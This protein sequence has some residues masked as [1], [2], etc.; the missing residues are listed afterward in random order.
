MA[1]FAKITEANEVLTVVVV[2]NSDVQDENNNEVESVG[3]QYLQTH[4]NWPAE[5]WIQCSYNTYRN[6]HSLGGT[7]FRGNY[8]SIGYTWD[9]TNSIF[10]E[11]QPHG[12]WTKNTSNASWEAPITYPSIEENYAIYWVEDVYQ[13]DNTK[14]WQA[15]KADE[16]PADKVYEWNGSAWSAK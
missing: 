4:S 9:P 3:Q 13:A 2:D 10:W 16:I 15:Y 11:P 12:S 6:V 1:H 7:A 8:A 5:K 14:G